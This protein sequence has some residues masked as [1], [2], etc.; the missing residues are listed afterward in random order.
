M[1]V[2]SPSDSWI[3][4]SL[5]RKEDARHLLGHGMFMADV[6]MS[7]MQDIAFVRSD[8]ANA[9]VRRVLPPPGTTARSS[10]SPTSARCISW[11]PDPSSPRTATPL[12]GAG[13]RRVRY[14]GQPVV[15]CMQPTRARPRISPIWWSLSSRHCPPSSIA[16]PRCGRQPAPVR[17]MAGQRLHRQ[18]CDRGRS[19]GSRIRAGAAAPPV[20]H[21][22]AGNGVARMPRRTGV[23]G[24]P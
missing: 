7:G 16:W 23:L 8:M 17:D 1:V 20:S 6:R 15:A 4:A 10:R 19:R 21:E 18:Q 11:K 22:P 13:R 12:P 5:L 24:L 2:P 9:R 3:G 14:A